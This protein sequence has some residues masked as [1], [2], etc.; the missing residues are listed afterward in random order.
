MLKVALKMLEVIEEAGFQ[1]YIVG[2][3][4]RDHLLGIHSNDVDI[5]TNAT[6]K[7]LKKSFKKLVYPMMIMVLLPLFL[8][9][10]TLKLLLFVK[11]CL[12]KI[13][14][15]LIKFPTSII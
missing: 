9:I 7:D 3:F 14:G 8:K 6:P 4:V 1:A 13:I 5:A 2:G 15:D 11:S 12:I 10:F